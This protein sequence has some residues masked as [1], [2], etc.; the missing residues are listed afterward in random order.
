MMI[1]PEVYVEEF[2]NAS[3]EEMMKER[4]RLIRYIQNFEKLE[5]VEDRSAD[6]ER[7]QVRQGEG[8]AR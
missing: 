8:G 1:G 3:Y 7:H 5:K 2:K 6:P 4:D